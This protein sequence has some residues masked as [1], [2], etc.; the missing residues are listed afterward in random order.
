VNFYDVRGVLVRRVVPTRRGTLSLEAWN[1]EDWLPYSD[2][3]AVLRFGLR[4]TE[5]RAMAL[6]HGTRSRI[7][8]LPPL[9]DREVRIV[10][11]AQHRL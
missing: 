11:R 4:V 1:G 7:A 2:V 6:L 9:S 8:S 3:D 10:L 5:A